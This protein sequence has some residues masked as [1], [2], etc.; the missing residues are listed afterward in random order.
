MKKLTLNLED[1]RNEQFAVEGTVQDGE[2][3]VMGQSYTYPA[4][5]CAMIPPTRSCFCTLPL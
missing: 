5:L 2:G 3:T 1:L 4:I